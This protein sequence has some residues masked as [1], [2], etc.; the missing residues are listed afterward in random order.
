MVTE[1]VR[2]PTAVGVKVTEIEQVPF[3]GIAL[4]AQLFVSAKSPLM[5]TV[6]TFSVAVPEFVSVI[7]WAPLVVLTTCDAKVSPVGF[8]RTAG[9]PTPVPLNGIVCGEVLVLSVRT[10]LPLRAPTAVGVKVTEMV[11]G[12]FGAMLAGQLLVGVKSPGFEP[13]MAM[14][15]MFSVEFPVLVTVI[16]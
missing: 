8:S 12:V 2:V 14:L 7:D 10:R 9:V 13:V 3:V 16:L 5:V 15:L 1:P 11:H 4:L 6:V